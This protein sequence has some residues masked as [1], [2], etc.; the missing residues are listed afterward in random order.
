MLGLERLPATTHAYLVNFVGLV[1]MAMSAVALKERPSLLQIVGALVAVL[2]LRVFFDEVP[3]PSE[4]TGVAFDSS[5]ACSPSRSYSAPS[6]RYH[7]TPWSG[8][9]AYMIL[10]FD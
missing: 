4:M 8:E 2:G 3:P 7:V 5:I 9:R 6:Y 1:T 10:W